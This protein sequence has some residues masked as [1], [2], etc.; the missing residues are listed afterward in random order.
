MPI[1]RGVRGASSAVLSVAVFLFL[2]AGAVLM[3]PAH[4]EDSPILTI[5][6]QDGT[7]KVLSLQD[8]D[9][10]PQIEIRTTTPWHAGVQTFSGPSLLAVLA[11]FD[12][13]RATIL[14]RAINNYETLLETAQITPDYPILATRQNGETMTV[15]DKGP[16][17]VIFPYD[18]LGHQDKA[19]LR[20]S[21]WQLSTL[22]Q[23]PDL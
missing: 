5:S 4:A 14:A 9:R 23:I 12:L 19:L 10:F 8:M 21:V 6:F 1:M 11:A 22:T 2:L 17:F 7:R 13:A 20:Q 18:R 15:R 16:I 3:R